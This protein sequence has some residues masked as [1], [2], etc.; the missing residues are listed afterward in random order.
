MF[1]DII[2]YYK[3]KKVRENDMAKKNVIFFTV[4]MESRDTGRKLDKKDV[5][6]IISKIISKNS[7]QGPEYNSVDISKAGDLFH[8]TID[9]YVYEQYF[10]G[11]LSRQKA[12]NSVMKRN[13]KDYIGN[14]VLENEDEETILNQGIEQYTYAYINYETMILA[15][16]NTSLAPN[17]KAFATMINKFTPQYVLVMDPIPNINGVDKF[18][19]GKNQVLRKLQLEIPLPNAEALQQVFGWDKEDIEKAIFENDNL[20]INISV[21]PY[22]QRGYIAQNDNGIKNLIDII[23]SHISVYKK[24]KLIGKEETEQTKLREYNF[25]DENFSFSI[26][27]VNYRVH[28]GKKVF[29][30]IDELKDQYKDNL[31]M[32]YNENYTL[33]KTICEK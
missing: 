8:E 21:G 14:D 22:N 12:S 29:F 26:D 13:Y 25:F 31:I 6:E 9:A 7:I 10:F 17:E 30:S 4:K 3:I 20:K 24:A 11:R 1:C 32:A 33:F 2:I 18:Y 28:A 23:K 16:V 5:V 15:I 27:I 19:R